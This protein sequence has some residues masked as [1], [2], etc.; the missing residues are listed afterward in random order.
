MEV[1]HSEE[2]QYKTMEEEGDGTYSKEVYK[3]FMIK[4]HLEVT[5]KTA[6]NCYDGYFPELGVI[7][8]WCIASKMVLK[9]HTPKSS[10][11]TTK[12][13]L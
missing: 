8:K 5:E 12:N 9:K 2:W 7:M 13:K 4:G 11:Q 1:G 3:M 6:R 10:G